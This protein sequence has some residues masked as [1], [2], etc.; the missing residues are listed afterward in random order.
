M[1]LRRRFEKTFEHVTGVR[2][3]PPDE[4]ISIPSH[5]ELTAQLSMPLMIPVA[6]GKSGIESKQ[7]MVKRGIK[8]PDYADALAYKYAPR[9]PEAEPIQALRWGTKA[10]PAKTP[11]VRVHEEL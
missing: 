5:S 10:A 2:E 4:L 11:H 9:R 7:D 8:S 6:G 1:T 3:Y